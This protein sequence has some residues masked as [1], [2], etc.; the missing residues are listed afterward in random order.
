MSLIADEDYVPES[1]SRISLATVLRVFVTVLLLG[2]LVWRLRDARIE[3]LFPRE[4]TR[5]TIFWI[6]AGIGVCLTGFA[7][8]AR[9]WELVVRV[10][11]YRVPWRQLFGH[12]LAGQFAGN[13][14]PSTIGGDVVRISRLSTTIDS[15]SDAFASVMIE[16]LTGWI[17]LPAWCAIGFALDPDLLHRPNARFAVT[18]AGVTLGILVAI[19]FL[20]GHPRLA[21]RFADHENWMRFIGALHRA[22]DALRRN[23]KLL[24]ELL[25]TAML[26]QLT[27]LLTFVCAFRALD[28]PS[29]DNAVFLAFLPTVTM[30]QVLPVTIGGLAMRENILSLLFKP[31]GIATA[32]AVGAGLLWYFFTLVASLAGIASFSRKPRASRTASHPV[33]TVH[34]EVDT[35]STP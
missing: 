26:Y 31:F 17:A 6:F 12:T 29:V 33:Q 35:P 25:A 7:C 11:G 34:Q 18:V 3:E 28:A 5:R 16:R 23:P 21:G 22:I 19:L 2:V 14:L 32:T 10:L 30:M 4:W 9:R 13:A 24:L 27:T 15:R 1:R 8:S 20:A